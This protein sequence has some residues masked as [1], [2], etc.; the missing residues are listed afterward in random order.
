[1]DKDGVEDGGG[2]PEAAS[3]GGTEEGDRRR[4]ARGHAKTNSVSEKERKI[5]H[6]RINEEGQV[7]Q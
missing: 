2:Q 4:R 6:R 3:G 1:M 5:G 7:R